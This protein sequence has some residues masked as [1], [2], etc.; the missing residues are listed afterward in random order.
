VNE[1]AICKDILFTRRHLSFGS[2]ETICNKGGAGLFHASVIKATHAKYLAEN[3]TETVCLSKFAERRPRNVC[4]LSMTHREYCVCVY[5][6][7]IRYK[8]L[9]LAR[10]ETDLSKKGKMKQTYLTFYCV[11]KAM[12]KF[13]T[14]QNT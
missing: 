1:S 13:T 8:L 9:A 3:E 12:M 6:I 14:K 4:K 2:T 10:I 11:L 5:C 7:N